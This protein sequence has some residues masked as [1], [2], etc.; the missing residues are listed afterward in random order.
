MVRQESFDY[1]PVSH[2]LPEHPYDTYVFYDK[3]SSTGNKNPYSGL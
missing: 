2:K 3:P 1:K